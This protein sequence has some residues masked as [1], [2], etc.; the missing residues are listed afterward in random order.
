[1]ATRLTWARSRGYFW[2]MV[3]VVFIATAFRLYRLDTVPRGLSHDEANNGL[4]AGEVLKGFRPPFFEIYTGVEPGL[5][6][7]Q[8]VAFW[9]L[10]RGAT[11][12]RLVSVA[13]GL[14]TVVLTYIFAGQ[15]F[16]SKLIGLISALLVA[17]SFWHV[18]VSRLGLRAVVMP[19]LQILALLFFWRALEERR[20]LHFALAGL[21]GGLTMYTYLSS[22]LLPLIPV[23]FVLYLLIRREDLRGVWPR[24]ATM[25]GVWLLVFLPLGIYYLNNPHWFLFRAEQASVLIPG[26][27]G[28]L[29][30]LVD[31]T[32]ATLGMFSFRGDPSWRYNL[33]GRP[34][35]DLVWAA[36]FY[37]GLALSLYRS[38][39]LPKV[40]PYAY[41][42]LIQVV[43]L[44]PDFVTDG[45]PHFL[46]TIGTVPTTFVFPAIALAAL[47][48]L[49]RPR[50]RATMAALLGI[51]VAVT[52][53]STYR[54]Y[55]QVWARNPQ[56]RDIYNASLA[57][58]GDYLGTEDGTG[59][60]MVASTSPELDRIAYGLSAAEDSPP[61]R[62]FDG[63]Q[64]LVI[65]RGGAPPRYFR[66]AT[67]EMPANLRV[68]L[69]GSEIEQVNGPDGSLSFEVFGGASVG[70]PQHPLGALLGEQVRVTGYDSLVPEYQAG[71]SLD[72]RLHWQVVTNPDPRRQ[73]SWF[74][75]LVDL[76]GYEWANWSGQGFEVAD[77]RP[78]DHV[79]QYIS[80]PIPFD[81]PDLVYHLEI[82][83][84]DRL[85]GERLLTA[86]GSD[87][88]STGDLRVNP[89]DEA[90]VAGLIA[91]RQKARLGEDLLFLGSTLSTRQAAPGTPLTMTLAWAPERSLSED[92]TFQLRMVHK[93]GTVVHE[94]SWLPL[95]GEYPTSHWPAR[96]IIRDVILFTIPPDAPPGRVSLEVGAGGLDG[97][98]S[99][100]KLTVAPVRVG[101]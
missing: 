7:P 82:G 80:L 20:T 51:W 100:G 39:K 58:I 52:A 49:V 67:T 85:S 90:S 42:L 74:V 14:L 15:L 32:L 2:A 77:W 3:V 59:P 36:A 1:M 83:M 25:A 50:W 21:F 46:R 18:F 30:R 98:V 9:L 69:E 16:K 45:S 93:D 78:D 48:G 97:S 62:W 40:N 26:E 10:G 91:G 86:D 101:P 47:F 64:A 38:V 37:A 66:P 31:E 56:A 95:D 54:D 99:A 79:V 94:Q 72:L 65:P 29:V 34:V 17:I 53:Y 81:A 11:T 12:E 55:F 4:M 88:V 87:H 41:I 70:N 68:L 27:A 57:E 84:Y 63:S 33:A 75:H 92:Y 73:W 23:G 28:G 71:E 61:V 76:R 13:F 43:M 22:R 6:Y 35:F 44:L 96:R 8:A 89:A 60:A 19:P 24:L 5:I